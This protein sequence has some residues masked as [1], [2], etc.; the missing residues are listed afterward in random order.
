VGGLGDTIV[1]EHKTG[2]DQLLDT[3]ATE[4]GTVR[5]DD[6]IEALAGV[7][8]GGGEL[9]AIGFQFRRRHAPIV[10]CNFLAPTK[11]SA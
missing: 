6:T 8:G 2:F 10:I 9:R 3:R 7:V 11:S 5:D 4:I 1:D